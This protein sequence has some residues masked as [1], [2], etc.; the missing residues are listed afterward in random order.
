MKVELFKYTDAN[1]RYW[2]AEADY[3][4]ACIHITH[5]MLGGS[6]QYQLEEVEE[7]QSGRDIYEQVDLQIDARVKR[8]MDIGYRT[9]QEESKAAT[10][11]TTLGYHRPMLAKRLD[12]LSDVNFD[13]CYVQMKYDGHR[14]LVT[15]TSTGLIAYSRNGRLIKSIGHI[16][17]GIK[18]PVGATIDGELY[19]HGTPLQTIGSWV[20]KLQPNTMRLHYVV[21]DTVSPQP[22]DLRYNVIKNYDLGKYAR[23]APTDKSVARD[24]VDLLLSTAIAMG[25]EGLMLRQCRFPYEPGKR[26]KALVKVKSFLDDEF[27]VV[28][29]NQSKDYWAILTCVTEDGKIFNVSAPGNMNEKMLVLKNKE[30]FIGCYVTVKYANLTADGIP[31]HPVAS[32]W[33]DVL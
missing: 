23:I 14:C 7:N 8:K 15:R 11:N 19:E 10:G 24:Q 31:F 16:L 18:I 6:M 27:K 28:D 9:S 26:S 32:S 30:K 2:C 22:Y 33:K 20:K 25:Y 4:R 12:Q 5:G 17:A 29:I 21:Y 1:I 13:D 3:D